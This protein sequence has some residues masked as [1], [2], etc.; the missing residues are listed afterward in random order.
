MSEKK[1][2]KILSS[3]PFIFFVF[4][5]SFNS[6]FKTLYSETEKSS[7]QK[8]RIIFL[9]DKGGDHTVDVMKKI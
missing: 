6:P 9:G 2:L 1:L 4:G 5:C 3:I 8:N 7:L